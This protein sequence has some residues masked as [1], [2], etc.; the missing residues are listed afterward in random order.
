MDI[1]KDKKIKEQEERSR[2]VIATSFLLFASANAFREMLEN[3]F[4]F[5][6]TSLHRTL[7]LTLEWLN[8]KEYLSMIPTWLTKIA[9]LVLK[10]ITW[11]T[12][13]LLIFFVFCAMKIMNHINQFSRGT[14]SKEQKHDKFHFDRD[15]EIR[16]L[17]MKINLE[18]WLLKYPT[19]IITLKIIPLTICKL[20]GK[21][22]F[23][24]DGL[25]DKFE[26]PSHW[27]DYEELSKYYYKPMFRFYMADSQ[28]TYEVMFSK[29][30]IGLRIRYTSEES[31]Q[32][33]SDSIGKSYEEIFKDPDIKVS[34]WI[35][36]ITPFGLLWN[37]IRLMNSVC[38]WVSKWIL[39]IKKKIFR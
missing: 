20:I 22:L 18:K 16:R 38:I 10:N 14:S 9:T 29:S 35:T 23:K 7:S 11:L 25:L 36:W 2:W 24:K 34:K 27:P 17:I 32:F 1:E 12:L 8:L 33:F 31:S 21:F 5:L 6:K 15:K 39:K 26:I 3:A 30:F 28:V 19:N 37:S 4:P 13:T